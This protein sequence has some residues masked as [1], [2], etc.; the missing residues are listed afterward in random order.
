[1]PELKKA[2]LSYIKK[3]FSDSHNATVSLL[4][5]TVIGTGGIRIFAE[6]LWRL[7][8]DTL[9]S[10]ISLWAAISL[11]FLVSAYAYMRVRKASLSSHAFFYLTN[12]DFELIHQ[13]VKIPVMIF[14]DGGYCFYRPP[15]CKYHDLELR[16][17]P[18]SIENAHHKCV[19]P[20]C[21]VVILDQIYNEL[22]GHAELYIS[23]YIMK[24]LKTMAYD[25]D[26]QMMD[27]RPAY[28]THATQMKVDPSAKIKFN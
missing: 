15:M 8:I 21:H 9:Q 14:N 24:N 13:D 10:E 28:P 16:N 17:A 1:M 5:V 2:I 27:G 11:I 7:L 22:E 20:D 3:I 12:K 23:K 18:G 6:D 4:C 19:K 26:A 25:R